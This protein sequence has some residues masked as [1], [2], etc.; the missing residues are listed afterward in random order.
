M[1]VAASNVGTIEGIYE[2][3]GRG[4][5]ASILAAL[6]DDVVWEHWE[7]NHAQAA[8][9]PWLQPRTGRDGAL[10]FFQVIG[11]WTPIRFEVA[12]LMEGGNKVVAE[13]EASF[14][15]PNGKTLAEQELHLWAFNENGKVSV[16][17][18]YVD[19]AKHIEA[20]KA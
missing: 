19:T 2:A 20:A 18:H 15:L 5:V 4:D 10:E 8:G 3:F 14:L 13:V 7:N 11:T 9:V 12:G 6:A 16:F 17:R 1:S